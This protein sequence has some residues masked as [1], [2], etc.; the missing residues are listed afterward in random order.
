MKIAPA[1]EGLTWWKLYSGLEIKILEFIQ[2]AQLHLLM[3]PRDV[4]YHTETN[5]SLGYLHKSEGAEGEFKGALSSRHP[6][7]SSPGTLQGFE[8][9]TLPMLRLL[10]PKAQGCK[11]F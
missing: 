10:S 5:I 9:L 7:I 2:G 8:T 6:L 3:L 4:V 11:D 1:V